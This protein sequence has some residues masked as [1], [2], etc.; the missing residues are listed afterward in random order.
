[1]SQIKIESFK[2]EQRDAVANLILHIQR[3]EFA[4]PVTLDDQPDLIDIPSFYQKNLGN[5]WVAKLDDRVVGTIALLD[6]GHAMGALRK[7]FVAADCRGKEHGVATLLLKTVLAWSAA[8]AFKEIY[9]G[10]TDRFLAAH[11]FYEK[12][13]FV[14]IPRLSLPTTF[15]IMTV[16][17]KFYRYTFLE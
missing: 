14:E 11:R 1:M 7:M 8:H 3:E 13:G 10:T 9:L 15:P 16:D 4:L 6:I 5:F 17:S 2:P 12:N